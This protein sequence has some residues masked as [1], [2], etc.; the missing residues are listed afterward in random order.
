MNCELCSY[1]RKV[2]ESHARYDR[3]G[4]EDGIAPAYGVCTYISYIYSGP[5]P[6]WVGYAHTIESDGENCAT[7]KPRESP[8]E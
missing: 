7:Y 5:V 2:T 6:A 1:W 3:S 4:H 8:D